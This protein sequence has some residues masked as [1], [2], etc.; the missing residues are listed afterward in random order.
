[1]KIKISKKQIGDNC[2]TFVVAEAGINH[3]GSLKIAK[4]MVDQAKIIGVDAIKFQTFKTEEFNS[5][6]KYF[7]IFKNA[8]LRYDE[9]EELS[10]YAKSKEIIFFSTPFSEKSADILYKL[11]VPM[12]K[13]ASGDI[14]H[15]PLLKHIASMK[16][17][18]IISTGMSNLKEIKNAI[19]NVKS[20]KNN[21][22]ILMHSVSAYPT[23]YNEVNM[24]AMNLLKEKFSYPIGYSDNGPG[25]LIPQ[26]A[27]SLGANIIE[28]H[29]T[30]DKKMKGPDQALSI[31]S[32]EFQ[33]LVIKI[34][35][36]EQILG[37]KNKRSQPSEQ[38]T[39]MAARRSIVANH[40]I[41]KGTKIS[42]NML[43]IKRPATGISPSKL[44][45][46]VG[47]NAKKRISFN[48]TIKWDDIS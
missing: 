30:L 2:P 1:M 39:K 36:I 5:N 8:E 24:M 14:T 33:E 6:E 27:A 7:K 29:F 12:F 18:I 34:R 23:P 22:I 43:S 11:K 38:E 20:K 37:K 15:S 3:N 44:N 32:K 4:K 26:I 48:Q 47:K 19:R 35:E 13:I 17:P 31:N 28:K 25:V 41:P 45:S 9:F 16:K 46:I 40:I 21:K 10:D 42:K